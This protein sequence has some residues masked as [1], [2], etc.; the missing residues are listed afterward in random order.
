V[1]KKKTKKRNIPFSM[2]LLIVCVTALGSASVGFLAKPA[3]TVYFTQSLTT[4]STW[5][6]T[7]AEGT[8]T[9]MRLC[10]NTPWNMTVITA[11]CEDEPVPVPEFSGI[12]L[13]VLAALFASVALLR[14]RRR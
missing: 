6:F 9:Y 2:L 8:A 3:Q 11:H 7:W 5:T 12:S 4:L 1:I 14:R 13:V 10:G